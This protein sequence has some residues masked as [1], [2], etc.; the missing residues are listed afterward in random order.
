[1][2]EDLL[3]HF[4]KILVQNVRDT[5]I[6]HWDKIVHGQ[7]NDEESQKLQSLDSS[8]LELIQRLIPKIVDTTIHYMLSTIEQEDTIDISIDGEFNATEKL[9]L[10]S[11][12]LAG[13]LY[14]KNGWIRKFSSQ[15]TFT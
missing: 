2:S 7:M 12:G 14:G 1:M 4:G 6:Q 15:R 9:S 11:D 13:E 8:E 5:S 10:E 3:N